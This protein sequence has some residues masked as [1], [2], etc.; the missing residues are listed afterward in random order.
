ML[1]ETAATGATSPHPVDA[2]RGAAAVQDESHQRSAP[3]RAPP[4]HPRWRNAPRTGAEQ[5]PM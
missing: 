2:Q 3:L 4:R 5:L 1:V